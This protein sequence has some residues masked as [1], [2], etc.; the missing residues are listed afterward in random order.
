MVAGQCVLPGDHYEVSVSSSWGLLL[1]SPHYPRLRHLLFLVHE[2]PH[3]HV[4]AALPACA[5]PLP[6]THFHPFLPNLICLYSLLPNIRFSVLPHPKKK[7]SGPKGRSHGITST[8]SGIN[9][10]PNPRYNPASHRSRATP[11]KEPN[12]KTAS[13]RFNKLQMITSPKPF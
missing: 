3:P 8:E 12:Q 1:P 2:L 11:G 4:P 9:R 13:P 5:V 7:D 10:W 6:R